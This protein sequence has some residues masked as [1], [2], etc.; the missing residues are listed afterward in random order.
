M[1]R[2]ETQ[3]KVQEVYMRFV[4][5]GKLIC[6]NGARTKVEVEQEILSVVSEYLKKQ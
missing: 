6:V 1:E 5:S 3:R 4:D 2:L